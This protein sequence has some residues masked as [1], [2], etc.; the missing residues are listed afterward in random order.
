MMDL[1]GEG[2]AVPKEEALTLRLRCPRFCCC[3]ASSMEQ[4][5]GEAARMLRITWM[6]SSGRGGSPSSSLLLTFI[7]CRASNPPSVN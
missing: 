4:V 6:L 3:S 7:V 1:V 2:L 5:G